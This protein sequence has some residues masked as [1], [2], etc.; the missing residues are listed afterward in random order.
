MDLLP[1]C[2][3]ELFSRGPGLCCKGPAAATEAGAGDFVVVVVAIE[4]LVSV[5]SETRREEEEE[6]KYHR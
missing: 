3:S 6:E 5:D 4:G 2:R 1:L